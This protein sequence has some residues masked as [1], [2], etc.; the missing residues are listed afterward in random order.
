MSFSGKNDT[1]QTNTNFH[2]N[3]DAH[4][5]LK[6]LYIDLSKQGSTKSAKNYEIVCIEVGIT[7]L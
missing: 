7:R 3:V 1:K 4:Y 2:A 5:S 6:P